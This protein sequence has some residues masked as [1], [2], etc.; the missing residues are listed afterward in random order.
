MSRETELEAEVAALQAALVKSLEQTT[1]SMAI[2]RDSQVMVEKYKKLLEEAKADY[3]NL[4]KIAKESQELTERVLD[5]SRKIG[6][7]P[8]G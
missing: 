4:L 1:E 2:A 6:G 7:V 3:A 5:Q 8:R